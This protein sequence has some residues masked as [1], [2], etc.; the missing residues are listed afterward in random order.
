MSRPLPP[1]RPGEGDEAGAALAAPLGLAG[2]G[3]VR[4]AAAMHFHQ[5]GRISDAALEAYRV[6]SARDGDDPVRMLAELGLAPPLADVQAPDALIGALVDEIALYLAGFDGPGLDECRRGLARWRTGPVTATP[7]GPNPVA[8][9]W[10]GPALADLRSRHPGL[11]AAIAGAEA[12]LPWQTY[13]GYAPEA[14]GAA[15]AEGHA[16]APLIGEGAAIPASDWDLGLFLVR[17]HVLYRDH[18][19]AAPELY[20]P[21][22]GPHGWRFGP[23]TPL[24]IL[25]AD[26]P[27]WN[28]PHRPHLTKVGP[29][30]FLCIYIWTR[31]ANAPA[32][33]LPASD[34]PA[35]EALR[36]EA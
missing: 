24:A 1:A 11:A 7:A 19:H 28:P 29:V 22:T 4:Y 12:H 16:Y 23:G 10:L 14:A 36:L 21:L 25:P 33:I 5:Q 8:G 31:A 17:P 26:R 20:A 35:L 32:R 3:R 6:C 27:V 18:S 9:D 2:S 15:F 30:P 34:W 13:D